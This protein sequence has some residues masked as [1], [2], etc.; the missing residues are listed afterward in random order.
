LEITSTLRHV[1]LESSQGV[2]SAAQCSP[3]R[4]SPSVD[5]VQEAYSLLKADAI[6][7]LCREHKCCARQ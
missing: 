3:Q 7:M 5:N 6:G 1:A 4:L 2:R